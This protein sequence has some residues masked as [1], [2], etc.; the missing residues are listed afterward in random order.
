M[1]TMRMDVAC[2]TSRAC[3]IV[4]RRH[5]AASH[6][7]D[8]PP[9]NRTQRY[10]ETQDPTGCIL[11]LLPRVHVLLLACAAA[12]VCL[13]RCSSRAPGTRRCSL[14]LACAVTMQL[15]CTLGCIPPLVLCSCMTLPGGTHH[16]HGGT[17]P[18]TGAPIHAPVERLRSQHLSGFASQHPP[19]RPG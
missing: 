7:R 13:L 19:S 4:R 10:T 2:T 8:L 18:C 17:H 9:P 1:D 12:H 16:M 5:A 6:R 3:Q 14:P 15:S 11:F